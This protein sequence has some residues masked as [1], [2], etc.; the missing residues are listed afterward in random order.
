MSSVPEIKVIVSCSTKF[1]AFA[2]AEQMEKHCIL[3]C[4]FTSYS[5]IKNPI[6]KH[7][8]SRRDREKIAPQNIAT[9]LLIAVGIKLYKNP[10]FWNSLFDRWVARQIKHSSADIFIGWSGM[11]EYS[12]RAAKK[13][14]MLTIL[15][16]GSSHISYQN[17]VL[18]D[19]YKR[20]G[21]DFSIQKEKIEKEVIEYQACDFI[22]IASTFVQRSFIKKGVDRQKL[23]LNPYGASNDF[24]YIKH[25][26]ES[27][28][29]IVLFFGGLMI[30]K[31][32][33]YL[34]EALNK[35][36]VPKSE[37]EVWFIGGVKEEIKS[38]IEEYK[39][40]N[41]VFK[42]HVEP[43][44]LAPLLS[45]G[46]VGI[47]PSIEDGFGMV[48]PQLLACKVPVIVTENT[49]SSDLIIEGKNGFIIPIRDHK[50]IKKLILE[51]YNKPNKL[52]E[53]KAFIA[54][55]PIDLSWDAYG[56]RYISQIRKLVK[57]SK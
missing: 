51:L 30:R 21:I 27:G 41:W 36:N 9:N 35:L 22:S 10:F 20:F 43:Q 19:E 44:N 56:E 11:S 5:S 12:I 50:A 57:T 15:E 2:L 8:I 46:S 33:V 24:R 29:F 31:G 26:F 7:F 25:D 28:K 45:H 4:F 1:H 17:E 42:G 3:E 49:G 14:G 16:R 40:E 39:R 18:K 13:K 47:V 52:K 38:L 48:V 55:N 54:N 32:L 37:Y 34:F 6:A 23:I 53:L